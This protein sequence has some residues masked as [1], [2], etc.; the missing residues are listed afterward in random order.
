[1]EEK[2]FAR[3]QELHQEAT[4]LEQRVQFID[5]QQKELTVFI[6]SLNTLP[7]A[8]SNEVLT[9]LGKGVFMKTIAKSNDLYVDV[10]AGVIIKR[11][12]E[13]VLET[14]KDQQHKLKTMR[15]EFIESLDTIKEEMTDLLQTYKSKE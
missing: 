11:T 5:E 8:H 9:S 2:L 7:H 1:M 4:E 12:P 13:Q 6:E 3:V 10:G 15:E 14:I